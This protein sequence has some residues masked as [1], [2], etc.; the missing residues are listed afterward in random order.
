MLPIIQ[1]SE[2]NPVIVPGDRE[3]AHMRMCDDMGGLVYEKIEL[4]ILV[5][6]TPHFCLFYMM[7]DIW[8]LIRCTLYNLN[9]ISES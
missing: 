1:L 2:D 8:W 4:E 3:R 7:K 5:S 6:S 9:V